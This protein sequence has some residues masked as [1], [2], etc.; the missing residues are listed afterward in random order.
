[1][2][3][4]YNSPLSLRECDLVNISQLDIPG[5]IKF[6][7]ESEELVLTC[8][9]VANPQV[10]YNLLTFQLL[11]FCNSRKFGFNGTRRIQHLRV[12]IM[13]RTFPVRSD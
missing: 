4:F 12:R 1:M 10:K 2:I 8:N 9:A 5:E 7:L 6:S 3:E 13:K 11:L